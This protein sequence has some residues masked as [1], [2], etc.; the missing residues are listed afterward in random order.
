MGGTFLQDAAVD[1]GDVLVLQVLELVHEGEALAGALIVPDVVLLVVEDVFVGRVLEAV[2]L[3]L[4]EVAV[5][6]RLEELDLIQEVCVLV[7]GK[8]VAHQFTD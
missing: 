6:R 4:V 8:G 1:L 5:F 7:G 3:E 2:H